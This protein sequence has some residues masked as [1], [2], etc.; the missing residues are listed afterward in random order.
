[1]EIIKLILSSGNFS[2]NNKN[3]SIF[4]IFP[5]TFKKNLWDIYM[6]M[7]VI[8]TILIIPMEIGM[9]FRKRYDGNGYG[10]LLDGLEIL[11]TISFLADIFCCSLTAFETQEGEMETDY[12]I[13]CY[14][15]T[16]QGI[17]SVLV[18]F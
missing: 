5:Y 12:K 15:I 7:I 9:A 6:F 18:L 13:I 3:I 10:N 2:F 1:M 8:Y 14:Y 11:I 4:V 16:S 17:S